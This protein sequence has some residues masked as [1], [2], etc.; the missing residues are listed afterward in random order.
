MEKKFIWISNRDAGANGWGSID[1][2]I[3]DFNID[4]DYDADEYNNNVGDGSWKTMILI[5]SM[6]IIGIFTIVIFFIATFSY[7]YKKYFSNRVPVEAKPIESE[8][9]EF[10]ED[11]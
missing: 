10:V 2:Y 1:V 6:A 4:I 9:T 7:L 3:A 11:L 5:V 8:N